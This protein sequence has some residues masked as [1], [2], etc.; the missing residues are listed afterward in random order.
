[1]PNNITSE[2]EISGTKEQIKSLIKRTKF[3]T[4]PDLETNQF[5][6]NGI[7][8]MPLKLKNTVSPTDLSLTKEEAE[9]KNADYAEH[10]KDHPY[11][12]EP[13]RSIT[14]HEKELRL[15][16]YGAINWYDWSSLHWGTKWNAYEVKYIAHE[17]TKIVL[18]I[19]TA[20]ST[21]EQIWETLREEGFTVRG[22][23]YGEM[24]GYE[25][26]GDGEE[27]FEAYEEVVVDYIG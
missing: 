27:V 20:W 26:I 8:K 2:V 18:S 24:D 6:F 9:K 15:K 5:D 19:D 10:M 7:K 22:V 11:K 23:A 4:K 25:Y 13:T 17:D 12:G 16:E 1:M 21:P 14:H 3:V